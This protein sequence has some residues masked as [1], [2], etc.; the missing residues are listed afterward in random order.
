[1][2]GSASAGSRSF[3]EV[4]SGLSSPV[5]VRAAPGDPSTLYVVEQAGDIKMVRNG[6]IVGTFLDIRS[7]VKSGGEL[8]MLSMAFHPDYRQNHLFYVSYTD[9]D[10][11]SRVVQYRTANG[12]PVLSS[13][14][15]LLFVRQPFSNHKGG[16]L[17]FDGQE[18]YFALGDGGSEGDPNQTSQN[19]SSRL[20]KML[21]TNPL[22]GG[23]WQMVGLGLRNPWRYSFDSAGNLWIADVGQDL[24]EEVDFRKAALVGQ[25]ANYGWSRY[26]GDSV[27][28]PSHTLTSKGALV[29]PVWVYSHAAVQGCAITGGYVTGRRYYYGDYCSGQIWSFAAGNSGRLSQPGPVGHVPSPVAFGL[30]GKTLYVVSYTGAIYKLG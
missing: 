25:L 7:R 22:H 13:A 26:E 18:L 27:Y 20:G 2:G 21:R 28:N 23:G 17:Q 15:Q 11:N 6:R 3:T 4:A 29:F 1:V 10:G 5:D 19:L 8:G 12:K 9:L 16:D 24:Y 14:K 30:V